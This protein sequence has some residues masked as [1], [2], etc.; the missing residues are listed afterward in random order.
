MTAYAVVLV[1]AS[2]VEEA[3]KI[4]KELL[5]EKLAACVNI[6]NDVHS[7]FWWKKEIDS[8]RE[9]LLV[10]KTRLDLFEQVRQKVRA[11]HSYKIPEIIALPIVMGDEDY[12][13]WINKE[14]LGTDNSV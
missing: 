13:K 12:L 6:L 8:A 10:I 3:Q 7:L 1:T 5:H 2:S 11:L 9:Y 14:I 4:A